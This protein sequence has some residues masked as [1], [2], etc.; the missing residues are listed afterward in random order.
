MSNKG[1]STLGFLK[2][3]KESLLGDSRSVVEDDILSSSV[4]EKRPESA[5]I[6]KADDSQL[7]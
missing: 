7:Q 6:F 3:T 1:G 2:K 4:N 5:K